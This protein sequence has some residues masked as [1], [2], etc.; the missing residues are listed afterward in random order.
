VSIFLVSG[1]PDEVAEELFAT[2]I[3]TASEV[4]RLID[5][6]GKVLVIPDAHKATVTVGE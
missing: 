5:T 1:Y 6:G 3:H 4:Q 2:P